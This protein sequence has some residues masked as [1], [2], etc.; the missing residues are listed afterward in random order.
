M[1]FNTNDAQLLIQTVKQFSLDLKNHIEKQYPYIWLRGEVGQVKVHTSGH[2]YFSLKE[3]D[4]VINAI[5][6]K[7]TVLSNELVEGCVMDIYCKCTT[8]PGRSTYQ[9]VAREA[10]KVDEKGNIL[11]QLEELKKKLIAEGLFDKERKK[12]LPQFP[13][14]IAIFTSPTGAV[15]HDIMHRIKDRFPCCKILFFPITVQGAQSKQSILMA[16]QKA[17]TMQGLENNHLIR[18]AGNDSDNQIAITQSGQKK[19]DIAILARGGGSLEDLWIFN[20]E[21]VVRQ[22]AAMQM[23]II[24]AIG[25]ETDTTLS[26]Y[27][28]DV[29]APTPTAAAEMAV[30]DKQ[31]IQ[32]D[33]LQ[34]YNW[35]N[36]FINELINKSRALLSMLENAK[37]EYQNMLLNIG[38]KIDYL[39]LSFINNANENIA[40][41]RF[42]IGQLPVLREIF[43]Q[44]TKGLQE[45]CK[46]S[47]TVAMLRLSEAKKLLGEQSVFI[48]EKERELSEKVI[49]SIGQARVTSAKQLNDGDQFDINFLDGKVK[50]M[51]IKS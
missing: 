7:G 20:D 49:L 39:I 46:N 27:A 48:Q 34:R 24:S 4:Y 26:D 41:K 28:A 6:W 47:Q 19:I 5:T 10:K 25:H 35:A 32:S 14:T 22:I 33:L 23:P 44:M 13:E 8:F 50:G 29:R 18:N 3:E 1:Q 17:N 2:T 16:L 42:S 36:S 11:F 30:P 9:I 40:K 37:L 12:Q 51:V 43:E 45:K 15:F 21:D 31:Q 38:Q